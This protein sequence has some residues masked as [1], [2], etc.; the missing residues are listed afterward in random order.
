MSMR[1]VVP[2]N[3]EEEGGILKGE[4]IIRSTSYA[5]GLCYQW[6]VMDIVCILTA[7]KIWEIY[8]YSR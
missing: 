7:S 6:S 5:P 8:K 2:K 3:L 1:E 4:K